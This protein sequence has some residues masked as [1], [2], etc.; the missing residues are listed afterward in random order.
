[1]LLL[2]GENASLSRSSERT[3]ESTSLQVLYFID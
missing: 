1:M 2:H 3:R